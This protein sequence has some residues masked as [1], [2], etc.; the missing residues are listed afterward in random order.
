MEE[1]DGREGET[2]EPEGVNG[3]EREEPDPTRKEGD[4]SDTIPGRVLSATI[5]IVVRSPAL[6]Q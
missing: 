6:E 1:D 4:A 3:R 2:E 5:D